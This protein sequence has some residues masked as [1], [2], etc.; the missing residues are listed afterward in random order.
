MAIYAC[1]L[2]PTGIPYKLWRAYRDLRL[3]Q[4]QFELNG[5]RNALVQGKVEPSWWTVLSEDFDLVGQSSAS[6]RCACAGASSSSSSGSHAEE[7]TGQGG[8]SRVCVSLHARKHHCCGHALSRPRCLHERPK[9][10]GIS[11]GGWPKVKDPPSVLH[12]CVWL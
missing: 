4:I 2:R 6:C 8:S 11:V 9:R 12:A 1:C 5:K 3:A 7:R 10:L